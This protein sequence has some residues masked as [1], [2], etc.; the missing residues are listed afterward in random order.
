M[1]V[2]GMLSS[3]LSLCDGYHVSP[4]YG[5]CG[6]SIYFYD[7]TAIPFVEL[8]CFISPR[9]FNCWCRNVVVSSSLMYQMF[10][11]RCLH[12]DVLSLC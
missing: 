3:P 6:S 4:D 11:L 2:F 7:L 8:G 1:F 9:T 5:F 10:I 12:C